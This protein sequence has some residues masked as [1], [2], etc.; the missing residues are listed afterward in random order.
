MREYGTAARR[1]MLE[2]DM[3]QRPDLKMYSLTSG[4][5]ASFLTK[6]EYHQARRGIHMEGILTLILC[7]LI[8]GRH[9]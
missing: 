8:M 3:C 7:D 9:L 5:H 1:T 4:G 6:W 2:W